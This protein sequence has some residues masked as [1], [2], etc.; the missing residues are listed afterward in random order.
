MTSRSVPRIGIREGVTSSVPVTTIICD[1]SLSAVLGLCIYNQVKQCGISRLTN[2]RA[3]RPSLHLDH[4]VVFDT[5]VRR[6]VPSISLNFWFRKMRSGQMVDHPSRT[7]VVES[8][9]VSTLYDWKY[10][11]FFGH[12]F[13]QG[14]ISVCLFK[15]N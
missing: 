5:T 9:R 3:L 12:I 2:S 4:L 8:G 14:W 13:V 15:Y 7:M 1:V 11:P 6:L 10:G